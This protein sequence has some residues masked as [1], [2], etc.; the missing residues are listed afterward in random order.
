MKMMRAAM[1]ILALSATPALADQSMHCFN[2]AGGPD[3][4]VSYMSSVL[5][6][7]AQGKPDQVYPNAFSSSSLRVVLRVLFDNGRQL[8]VTMSDGRPFNEEGPHMILRDAKGEI[9]AHDECDQL[10]EW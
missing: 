9:L 4:D 3:Y 5:R 6:I 2:S 10:R 8:E 1:M 7:I